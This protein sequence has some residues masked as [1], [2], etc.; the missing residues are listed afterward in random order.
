MHR[1]RRIRGRSL[2]TR[3]RFVPDTP[4]PLSS[5]SASM[6]EGG[7]RSLALPTS[8]LCD[9]ITTTIMNIVITKTR[10]RINIQQPAS[11]KKTIQPITP[12]TARSAK[13]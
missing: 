6:M 11:Y 3:I 12:T 9:V 2:A 13:T 5:S 7:L 4:A 10:I 1:P 8:L